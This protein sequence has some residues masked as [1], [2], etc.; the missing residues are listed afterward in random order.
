MIN[1]NGI[2]SPNNHMDRTMG[3]IAVG[4][5]GGVVSLSQGAANRRQ[6]EGFATEAITS[7]CGSLLGTGKDDKA[8]VCFGDTQE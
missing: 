7:F 4:V 6:A 3:A 2:M 5:I 8:F 1:L